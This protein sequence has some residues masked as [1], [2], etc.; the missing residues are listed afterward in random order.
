MND[1]DDVAWTNRVVRVP[2]AGNN[3]TVDLD[4]HGALSESEVLHERAHVQSVGD[5]APRSIDGHFHRCNKILA[6]PAATSVGG[7]ETRAQ[8][9]M[10]PNF[11]FPS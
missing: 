1:L 7:L 9:V 10:C 6:G 3:D 4:G 5:V 8:P 2:S 11:F